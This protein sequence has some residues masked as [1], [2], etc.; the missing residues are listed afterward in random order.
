MGDQIPLQPEWHVPARVLLVEDD[1]ILALNAKMMLS[2][3]GV[4]DIRTAG[5]VAAALALIDE[6]DF[7][8]GV[9]DFILGDETCLPVAQRLC[10]AQIP[11]LITTGFLDIELPD[12]CSAAQILGKPYRFADLKRRL[13]ALIS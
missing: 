7:D 3:I 5:S 9:L 1:A 13:N 6:T 4:A 11:V 2:E 12:D 8:C 10:H